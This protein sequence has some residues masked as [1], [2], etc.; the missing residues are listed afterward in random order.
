MFHS[1]IKVLIKELIGTL[2]DS[3]PHKSIDKGIGRNI[4]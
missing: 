2:Y 1:H 3:L 4:I